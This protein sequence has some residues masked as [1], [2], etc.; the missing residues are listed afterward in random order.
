MGGRLEQ[1]IVFIHGFLGQPTDWQAVVKSLNLPKTSFYFLDLNRHFSISELNFQSWPEAFLRWIKKEKIPGPLCLVG[2]SLG[3]RLLCPL[4]EKNF[5][6]N[7]IFI[8]S[9]FGFHDDELKQ[10]AERRLFSQTWAKKFLQEP[11]ENV[12]KEWQQQAIFKNSSTPIRIESKFDR[13]KLAATLTGFSASEQK[14][15]SNLWQQKDLS[16]LYLA[17]EN[18]LKYKV[19]GEEIQQKAINTKV[20]LLKNAGHRLLLDQPQLV[21]Q[22]LS[23]FIKLT[24]ENS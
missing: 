11:W 6:K 14:Y 16:L 3:G 9:H 2:Y 12:I 10:R 7:A 20:S 24:D 15:F 8:S 5:A 1:S 22:E 17:G 21:A 4:L 23:K 13:E 18:D 19:V